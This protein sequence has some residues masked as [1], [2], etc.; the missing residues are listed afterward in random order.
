MFDSIIA[1]GY[2]DSR[3][4]LMKSEEMLMTIYV[5]GIVLIVITKYIL[6][7]IPVNTN[8]HVLEIINKTLCLC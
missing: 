1:S 5:H 8:I 7:Y 6:F 2:I 4:L 3:T